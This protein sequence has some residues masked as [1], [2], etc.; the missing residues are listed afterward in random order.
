MMESYKL[1]LLILSFVRGFHVNMVENSDISKGTFLNQ[2]LQP[3]Q[4][5]DLV[6]TLR[7]DQM[8]DCQHIFT[9]DTGIFFLSSLA[10]IKT[11]TGTTYAKDGNQMH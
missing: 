2:V 11:G 4:I 5:S 7:C 8:K 10:E 1:I 3:N 9:N 6:A